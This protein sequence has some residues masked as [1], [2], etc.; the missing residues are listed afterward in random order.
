MTGNRRIP[1][2]NGDAAMA[3]TGVGHRAAANGSIAS[4]SLVWT[5]GRAYTDDMSWAM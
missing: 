4:F 5:M 1:P 2:T 3:R